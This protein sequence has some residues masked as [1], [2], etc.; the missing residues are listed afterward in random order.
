MEFFIINIRL[1]SISL[2]GIGLYFISCHIYQRQYF[3]VLFGFT[4]NTVRICNLYSDIYT[5]N[6][7]IYSFCILLYVRG[8]IRIILRHILIYFSINYIEK[9]KGFF[10]ITLR[11][12]IA[13]R[14][15]G[16]IL[17]PNL[18]LQLVY[19]AICAVCVHEL[20]ILYV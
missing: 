13:A 14:I 20:V 19:Y 12:N 4:P 2:W 5:S 9:K 16:K 11:L 10:F 17:V 1:S 15:F 6:V 18:Y 3:L 7:S 8:I